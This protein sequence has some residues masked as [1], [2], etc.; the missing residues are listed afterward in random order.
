MKHIRYLLL[1]IVSTLIVL[2]AWGDRGQFYTSDHLSSSLITCLVQDR[3]GFVWAG[4][5]YGLSRFDGYHFTNYFRDSQDSTSIIDN[6][7]SSFLVDR[8]G[9]LWV[10]T[11]KGL[12]RYDYHCNCFERYPMPDGRHPRIYSLIES[13]KGDVLIGTAGYGLYSVRRG[14]N[15]VTFEKDYSPRDSDMFY[16]HI[17]EDQQGNLWQSS[18]LASFNRFHRA[19]GRV[20]IT[21]YHSPKGAPV[22]F[23]QPR[24]NTLLIVCMFG[25]MVYDYSTGQL[26]DA[27][28]DFGPYADNISINSATFDRK[29]NLYVGTSESGLLVC[30]N[31]TRSFVPY[32]N[33]NNSSFD[34]GSSYVTNVMEDRDENLWVGCYKKGLYLVNNQQMAFSSWGFS[35]QNY[36][37]GSCVSSLTAGDDGMTWCTVQN[38]GVFGFDPQGRIVSHPASPV[39][40]SIIYRDRQDHYWVAT[41]NAL[42]S[43]QPET[44]AYV[45]KMRFE[46]AGVPAIVDDG[47]GKLFISVYSKGLYVYDTNTQE[48]KVINMSQKGRHGFLCNDW[49][50]AMAFDR[51]GM[52]WL[53]T[54]NGV[55]CMDPDNYTFDNY[56][57]NRILPNTQINYICEGMKGHIIFG[58]D[59][60]LYEFVA[61]D[62]KTGAFPHAEPLHDKQICG[63]VRDAQGD[64]WVS[65]TKGIW[66]YDHKNQKFI[67]HINGNGLRG[68]EYMQGAVMH[69]DGSIIG[70]G[71]PDGIVVFRP[72]NVRGKAIALGDVYL[73]N[74]II[75]GKGIDC[76]NDHFEVPYSQN[77][78]TLEFS[79]LNYKNADNI[80]FQYRVNGGEWQ[81][82]AE[83]MNSVNFNKLEPDKYVV[84]VRAAN[85]GTSSD[86]IRTITIIVKAPWYASSLAY[87]VYFL[88]AFAII[89]YL[90]RTYEQR[91]KADLDEQKM[92][93]LIDATHDIRSP[94]TLI[95][96]PLHKLRSRITDS[97]NLQDINTID[98]NAQRLLQLVNQILDERKIDKEQM[99][100]H[101]QE[102]DLKE[103]VVG[104]M[105]LFS[106]NAE[107]RHIRLHSTDAEGHDLTAPGKDHTPV[108]VWIDRIN[109]DKV[110]T[111][112]LSNAMKYT[113]DGGEVTL[114]VDADDKK[115]TLKV[116]D[117]GIGFKNEKTDRLF[118]R[119]YQGRNTSDLH[120][121]GTGIGLNLCRS[122]VTMHG[123]K[124]RAY[125]RTDGS[126][127]AC[128]EVNLPLGNTHL[129]PE[130]IMVREE[131]TDNVQQ[132]HRQQAS[133]NFR[134]LV[135][136]DDREIPRY[137]ANELGTWYHF[138]SAPNGKEAL[139]KL[140][141][142]GGVDLVISDVMMPEMDGIALLKKI[143]GNPQISDIPVILLT[144]K[145][146]VENRMEGL[147]KGADAFLS[148]PFSM[149]E[150]HILIDNLVDNYRRLRGKFSGAQTQADKVEK[151]EVK[152]N[153]DQLMARIMKCVNENLSDPDFN[154]EKLTEEVGI[155]RA[156]LHRKMKEITGIST[157]EFIRNLRLEQAAQLI[158]KG[159]INVTQV[160]YAVGFNNQAHFSTV[161]KRHFGMTPTEY[162]ET[163][164]N[165]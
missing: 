148:K 115:A 73:T 2:L 119:F 54:S 123:G 35:S 126:Q 138:D 132:A 66:Q 63:I 19:G 78:F 102:T 89:A 112:L 107:T 16:T 84:E 51:S 110:V 165:V 29:G 49:V 86:H 150:L 9:N 42:Y 161:F 133:K 80:S 6:T 36:M 69:T 79:T 111:N 87:L 130:E 157:G 129:K 31:D 60:G 32:V 3:Y 90:L 122:I 11:A 53:G 55:S 143:K 4:T 163:K 48:V 131:I 10:G 139:K 101:C 17:Y 58:T 7:I 83:G 61:Q 72:E 40:T 114:V 62:N 94:L 98:R 134:V 76:M 52:L 96:D 22:A 12:M 64:L 116:I 125:N 71:M 37:T 99:H 144:S 20:H 95:M 142:E 128:L 117:T 82:T 56:G 91:R 164:R 141:G 28:Y 145:S 108:K 57:W 109:F 59:D 103:F 85:N 127:G 162:Y 41:P 88:L 8:N 135:V 25:I 100:L 81:T 113:Y 18:H 67:G 39:G 97:E 47:R 158:K 93:F 136:D 92:R 26:H 33:D 155:S 147:K 146:E 160:A 44:G 45:P 118:E 1:S 65:T 159:D 38:S 21:T 104:I 75:D 68:H 46:S 23:F 149:E 137:I 151:V 156:Q 43:Y 13:H 74:F 30:A 34:L 70:F 50:R 106:F 140:L 5:E 120:I 27:D 14:S 105:R 77:S 15:K 24:R 153:N 152:G 124:I 121:E 154:V